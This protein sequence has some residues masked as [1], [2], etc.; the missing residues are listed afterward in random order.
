MRLS[1]ILTALGSVLLSRCASD[2]SEKLPR[3]SACPTREPD[4]DFVSRSAVLERV[5]PP[6]REGCGVYQAIVSVDLSFGLLRVESMHCNAC[7]SGYAI[8][9]LIERDVE[10]PPLLDAG[11]LVSAVSFV[12]RDGLRYTPLCGGPCA[13][14]GAGN[15]SVPNMA[16]AR[17]ELP[18]GEPMVADRTF[19]LPALLG[20]SDRGV[21]P[22]KEWPGLRLDRG[23]RAF[24]S[25]PRLL[26]ADVEPAPQTAVAMVPI[27]A[28]EGLIWGPE[29]FS[30]FD[31]S[32][33][34]EPSELLVRQE[35]GD[36]RLPESVVD[37]F[38]RIER[39][40]CL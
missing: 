35:L 11:A 1:L 6:Y 21:P 32:Q 24:A 14:G 12:D 25:W 15:P 39:M 5:F 7:P 2:T 38:S 22:T 28:S 18:L 40:P 27:C 10:G 26:S 19:P 33:L 36:L 17:L 34:S 9:L 31:Y 13:Y 20:L 29:E 30:R 23:L 8:D 3:G 37:W 4:T 16:I